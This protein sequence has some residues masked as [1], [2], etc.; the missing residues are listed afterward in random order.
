VRQLG[1]DADRA[2]AAEGAKLIVPRDDDKDE[3]GP[4]SP[5]ESG[6]PASLAAQL[7]QSLE[8]QERRPLRPRP[9]PRTGSPG[10]RPGQAAL[11]RGK[12]VCG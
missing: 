11:A 7:E 6:A 2:T 10:Q 12:C 8:M 5:A 1:A 9:E 3:Q 4:A